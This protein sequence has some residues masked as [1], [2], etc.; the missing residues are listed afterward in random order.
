MI[1][2]TTATTTL[3]MIKIGNGE[4][5]DQRFCKKLITTASEMKNAKSEK[6]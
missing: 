5:S 1:R 6:H 4:N 2:I 3:I